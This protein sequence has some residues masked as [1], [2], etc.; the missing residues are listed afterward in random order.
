MQSNIQ[1][2]E[3]QKPRERSRGAGLVG[4]SVYILLSKLDTYEKA[5]FDTELD[6]PLRLPIKDMSPNCETCTP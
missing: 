2:V 1:S 3:E 5:I 6:L 4:T